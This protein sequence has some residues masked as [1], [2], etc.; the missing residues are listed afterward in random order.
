MK[1]HVPLQ[2][3]GRGLFGRAGQGADKDWFYAGQWSGRRAHRAGI[4]RAGRGG[5]HFSVHVNAPWPGAVVRKRSGFWRTARMTR[6]ARCRARRCHTGADR[7]QQQ[8]HCH[9]YGETEFGNSVHRL[10]L[11]HAPCQTCD[12]RKSTTYG[13]QVRHNTRTPGHFPRAYA[14]ASRQ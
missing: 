3:R 10:P 9:Q 2:T 6:F 11:L 14:S 4:R 7:T 5:N 8:H 12:D 1:H 13:I